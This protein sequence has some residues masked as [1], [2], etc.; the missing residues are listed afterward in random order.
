[1]PAPM[2][3]FITSPSQAQIAFSLEPAYN[4]LHSM[5]LLTKVD[6]L[7]GLNEWVTRTSA[8]LNPTEARVHRL[9]MVGFYYAVMPQRS[10]RS[11][12]AYLDHLEN[13]NPVYL[14][15]KL[16]NTYNNLPL[17][18][19]DQDADGTRARPKFDIHTA[20]ETSETYLG[21]LG[22]RFEECYI[23]IE[24]ENQ[25]YQYVIDPPAMQQLIVGHLRQMW[26]AH[27]EPEWK[28]T[29]PMLRDSLKAFRQS[30]TTKMDSI[31]AAEYVIGQPLDEHLKKSVSEAQQVL[32][33]PSAHIG[34]YVSK[35]KLGSRLGILFGARLP[36][37]TPI[38]APDL[39]RNEIL[40]RLNALADDT[41][42][43]ILKLIAEQGELR[44]HDIMARLQL[45]QSASSR[46]LKQLSATSY[47]IERR[48]EGAKCYQ[49]NPDRIEDTLH[50][51]RSFLLGSYQRI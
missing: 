26:E 32:F 50:A 4:A 48:C 2:T 9:V 19:T 37:G 5:M 47:L 51:V 16:L 15:D 49:L 14:R 1:M 38:Y 41:R 36:E 39:S 11:F 17:C 31:E 40:V 18:T 33:V 42:L 35:F 29:L 46:H 7:S 6:Q 43:R 44:S 23:D 12:P 28:R 22:E 3:D 8:A 27:L 10:W 30:N 20:L 45:S 34:P 13:A 25:A 21:F 24:L